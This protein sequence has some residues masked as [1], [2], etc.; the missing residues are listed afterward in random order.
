MLPV[1]E[2]VSII[3]VC[4]GVGVGVSPIGVSVAVGVGVGVARTTDAV[5]DIFL[6]EPVVLI[7]SE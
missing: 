7:S 5:S 2:E 1:G 6:E 3:G 4:V